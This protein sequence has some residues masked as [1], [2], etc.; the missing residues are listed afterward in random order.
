M[1]WPATFLVRAILFGRYAE[2]A[3]HPVRRII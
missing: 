1:K 2:S 3:T